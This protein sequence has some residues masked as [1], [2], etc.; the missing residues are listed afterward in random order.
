MGEGRGSKIRAVILKGGLDV[1]GSFLKRSFPM[2]EAKTKL[3]DLLVAVNE[4]RETLEFLEQWSV[5]ESSEWYQANQET[6]LVQLGLLRQVLD[7]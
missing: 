2:N 1:V 5:G 4:A 6:L 3:M 7:S